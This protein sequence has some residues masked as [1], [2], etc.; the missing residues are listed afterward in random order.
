MVNSVET[1]K[2]SC[3]IHGCIFLREMLGFVPSL[4]SFV[5]TFHTKTNV[6]VLL[7]GCVRFVST[8][9][10]CVVL[11]P[12]L[13]LPGPAPLFAYATAMWLAMTA[14]LARFFIMMTLT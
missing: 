11:V 2:E 8:A 12:L 4:F 14:P 5:L 6:Y 9:F 3:A 1:V 10:L 7:P 13:A